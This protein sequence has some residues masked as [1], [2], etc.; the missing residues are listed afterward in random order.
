MIS[1]LAHGAQLPGW[2]NEWYWPPSR[3]I[4]GI[5]ACCHSG[6][7]VQCERA[8]VDTAG[9]L[10]GLALPLVARSVLHKERVL[11]PLVPRLVASLCRRSPWTDGVHVTL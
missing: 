6:N 2:Q 3:Y 1:A 10:L 9:P 4:H 5:H 7:V 8:H 11:V